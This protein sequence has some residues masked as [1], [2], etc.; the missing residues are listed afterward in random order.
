MATVS[1]RCVTGARRGEGT[2]P[3]PQ[4]GCPVPSRG[5]GSEDTGGHSLRPRGPSGHILG[6]GG[7]GG[8]ASGGGQVI[9]AVEKKMMA[10]MMKISQAMATTTVQMMFA[11]L[12]RL[13]WRR[14]PSWSPTNLQSRAWGANGGL[15]LW[16]GLT[17][18]TNPK[19][20]LGPQGRVT[21]G[22]G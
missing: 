5:A 22:T 7:R 17:G 4:P 12:A 20:V 10:M 15:G 2:S 9:L 19:V 3:T 14:A 8:E 13:L 1:D 21:E 18:G 16:G 6:A 11:T